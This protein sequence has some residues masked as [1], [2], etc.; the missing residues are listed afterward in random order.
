VVLIAGAYTLEKSDT[1][2]FLLVGETGDVAGRRA[3]CRQKAL[4][5]HGGYDVGKASIAQLAGQLRVEGTKARSEN[6]RAD[7]EGFLAGCLLMV[8]GV[9][10]AGEYTLVALGA[11]AAA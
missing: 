7:I 6:D 11:V 8:Y 1:L 10:F 9:G 5:L 3:G 4:K 2:R